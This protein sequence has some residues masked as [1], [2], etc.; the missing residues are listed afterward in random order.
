MI[1]QKNRRRARVIETDNRFR[2]VHFYLQEHADE[3]SGRE[4]ILD[5][6]NSEFQFLSLEDVKTGQ[7]VA[8]NKQ[9]I[10]RVEPEGR[11]LLEGSVFTREISVQ[12]EMRDGRILQGI[13]PV[14]SPPERSRLSDHLNLTPPFLYLMGQEKDFIVNKFHILSVLERP[15]R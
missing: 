2:D 1:I 13:F 14:E 12:V 8:V 5:V 11:D 7:F 4:L 9:R 15:D 10:V 3:H 6:L